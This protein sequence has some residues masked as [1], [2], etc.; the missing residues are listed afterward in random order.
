MSARFRIFAF[1]AGVLFLFNLLMWSGVA[2]L[3]SGGEAAL[4]WNSHLNVG[5]TG[6]PGFFIASLS[7][8]AV[9]LVKARWLSASLLILSLLLFNWIGQKVFTRERLIMT[10]L[11]L[12]SSL[13]L[14][15]LGKIATADMYLFVAHF[16]GFL[17]L[18]LFLRQPNFYWRGTVYFFLGLGLWLHPLSSIVFWAVFYLWMWWR[19]PNGKTLHQLWLWLAAPLGLIVL[20]VCHQLHWAPTGFV[21]S[22]S[23]FPIGKFMLYSLLGLAPFWGYLLGGWRDNALMLQKKEEQ[24]IIYTGGLLAGLLSM[25]VSWQFFLSLLIA[26]QMTV[27]FKENYPFREWVKAGALIHLFL[28]FALMFLLLYN[29]FIYFKGEGFRAAMS[30]S[31]A[32][33]ALSFAGIVG[34]YGQ[35]RALALGASILSGLIGTTF[36][37]VQFYPL[38]ESN[39]KVATELVVEAKK[40]APE[41]TRLLLWQE[42]GSSLS[43]MAVYGM[44][45]FDEVRLVG[46]MAQFQKEMDEEPSVGLIKQSPSFILPEGKTI[47]SLQLTSWGDWMVPEAWMVIRPLDK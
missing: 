9:D 22:L 7:T 45:A 27:Y 30:L 29:G 10:L 36:F 4:W 19:H 15:N 26:K 2:T 25:S 28:V 33:W 11:V 42:A 32:Y 44:E 18:L 31:G 34:L 20:A 16:G 39:R 21:F 12:V 46:E 40:A 14:P 41:A 5:E 1:V 17:S 37:W 13:M 8:L 47:D 23:A 43:N 6:L 3:W 24:A 35:R 38:V